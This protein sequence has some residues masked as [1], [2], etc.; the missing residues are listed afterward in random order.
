MMMMMMMMMIICRC[1]AGS[2]CRQLADGYLVLES[3]RLSL[4]AECS[5]CGT[6][7]IL[8]YSWT[9]FLDDYR[10]EKYGGWR[11]LELIEL[12]KFHTIGEI[13]V[14]SFV[15]VDRLLLSLF[16]LLFFTRH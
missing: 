11:P 4:T 9:I 14:F 1:T 15:V 13:R 12:E 2:V 7:D 16:A 6:N 10:W 3:D 8:T 5:N